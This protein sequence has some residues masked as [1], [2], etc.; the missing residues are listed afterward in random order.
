MRK[1]VVVEFLSL[2]GVYQAPGHP[3]EDREG[4]FEHEGWQ[5]PYF[6]EVMGQAAAEGMADRRAAVRP[7][8]VRDDGRLLAERAEGRPVRAAPHAV[9][10]DRRAEI[11]DRVV[12]GVERGRIQGLGRDDRHED[13]GTRGCEQRS[14]RAAIAFAGC[15]STIL[16]AG[17]CCCSRSSIRR[18]VILVVVVAMSSPPLRRW[19]HGSHA[20]PRDRR[21]ST[22]RSRVRRNRSHARLED[23]NEARTVGYY[24]SM[25]NVRALE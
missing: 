22:R 13:R 4:G 10:R 12:S 15:S 7:H 19:S 24:A 9:R 20:T 6:D 5:M 3:D 2:D 16:C 11:A 1:L 21:R 17:R 14:R 25:K 23:S 8:D 18:G